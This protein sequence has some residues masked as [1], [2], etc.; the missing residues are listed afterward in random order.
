[1][2]DDSDGSIASG[3]AEKVVQLWDLDWPP[4]V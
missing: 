1:M 2:L 4:R 3:A